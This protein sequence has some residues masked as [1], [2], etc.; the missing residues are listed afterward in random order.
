MP[1]ATALSR[2]RLTGA[3]GPEVAASVHLIVSGY[4]GDVQLTHRPG[5]RFVRAG[6]GSLHF[7]RVK[8]PLRIADVLRGHVKALME[9]GHA[10]GAVDIQILEFDRLPRH[11]RTGCTEYA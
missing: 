5:L 11:K 9:G 6:G 7:D 8:I 4:S 3:E 1:V 2:S 10:S